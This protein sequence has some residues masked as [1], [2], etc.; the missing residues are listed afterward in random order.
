MSTNPFDDDTSPIKPPG[1]P[2]N[3]FGEDGNY[4]PSGPMSTP[5]K[6]HHHGPYTLGRSID[7]TFPTKLHDATLTTTTMTSSAFLDSG[8]TSFEASGAT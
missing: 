1:R 6:S 7:P 5:P 4:F 2:T 8:D 3:P